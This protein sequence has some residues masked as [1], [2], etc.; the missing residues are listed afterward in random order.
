MGLIVVISAPSG[1]GKTTI[2]REILKRG[3]SRYQYSI[4]AT[5]REPRGRERDGVDYFFLD[6]DEFERRIRS[7][8]FVEWAEVHGHWYGTPKSALQGWLKQGKIILLDLDVQ[9]GLE[10]KQQFGDAALLIFIMPPSVQELK[11]RLRSR[12]TDS[13]AV[14]S[15]RL[16]AVPR[17]IEMAKYYD[18]VVINKNL[19]EAVDKVQEVIEKIYSQKAGVQN[20]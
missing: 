18:V 6:R 15:N 19:P 13:A 8:D 7:G 20:G 16:K 5:T 12:K 14:I 10:V 4:S 2:I 11:A 1:G 17:E 3:D 9:G